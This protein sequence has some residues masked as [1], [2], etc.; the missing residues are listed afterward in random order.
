M[1]KSITLLL[2]TIGIAIS[3]SKFD[4]TAIWDKLND[5]EA[6][7][8]YLE[9]ICEKMNT[10]IIN[11]QTIVTALETNDYI[12]N[13]SPLATGDGYTLI[14][15]SGKS[16]VIYNGKD[17]ANG[18]DG[19]DGKD[20]KDGITPTISVMKDID[21]VYYWTINNEW[22]LVSG[23]KV[24]ASVSDG[25]DGED[26]KDGKDG[27]NGIT[28]LLKIEDEYWY[29]SYNNGESWEKLGKATGN[30]GQNGSNGID[31]DSI[32]SQV[33]QDDEFVYFHLANGTMITLPKHNTENI[34]FEDLFVKAICCKNW[35]TNADGELSYDEAKAIT[36]IDGIFSKNESI[37]AFNE[38]QYFTGL[39]TIPQKAFESC[40]NLWKIKLPESITS[41]ESDAFYKCSSLSN[42]KIPTNVISI[43]HGAFEQCNKL[44]KVTFNK[45][46]EVIGSDAF[47]YCTMLKSIDLSTAKVS[48]INIA[49]FNGCERLQTV[50]LGSYITTLGEHAFGR[51][52]ITEVYINS[53]T[54]P[55]INDSDSTSG[56]FY[57]NS[58]VFV[59]YVPEE[60]VETYKAHTVWK[61]IGAILGYK[62]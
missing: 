9:E 20:G 50:H 16:I 35:D 23:E 41:I 44:Q 32:F 15:K 40:T 24:K 3:C 10:D 37:I 26:G 25:K 34:Q 43:G 38:F 8:A 2:M 22:L 7:L 48:I 53:L 60:A 52:G 30:D 49:T 55:T 31:G 61:K 27:E 47:Y 12:V 39:S 57:G 29:I 17:G 6:R 28:P 19:K 45:N 42:I 59:V 14:F 18:A 51:C 11:L 62:F 13:A 56:A 36:T 46:L 58:E 5:H 4:D 54:P 1:K 33:T 21:G